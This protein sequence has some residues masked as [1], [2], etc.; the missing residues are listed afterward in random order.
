MSSRSPIAYRASAVRVERSRYK[1][2][3]DSPAASGRATPSPS[4][5]GWASVFPRRSEWSHRIQPGSF[6]GEGTTFCG[7]E[8]TA[9]PRSSIRVRATAEVVRPAVVCSG[10]A[11]GAAGESRL[12]MALQG[13][14]YF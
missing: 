6:V 5:S 11:P 10:L 14:G 1:G 2:G 8:A 13:P 12:L 9:T 3:K 4:G 7:A